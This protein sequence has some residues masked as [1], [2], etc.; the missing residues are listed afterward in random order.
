LKTI[1]CITATRCESQFF[2]VR[3]VGS[4][5]WNGIGFMKFRGMLFES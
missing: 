5:S 3:P 4:L 1:G 2:H